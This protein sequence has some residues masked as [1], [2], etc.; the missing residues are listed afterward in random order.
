MATSQLVNTDSLG[1]FTE[2]QPEK[3]RVHG[4]PRKGIISVWARFYASRKAEFCVPEINDSVRLNKYSK[5]DAFQFDMDGD[6][7]QNHWA[8]KYRSQ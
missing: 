2:V 4:N 3:L 6:T 5:Y 1:D 8:M 7:R